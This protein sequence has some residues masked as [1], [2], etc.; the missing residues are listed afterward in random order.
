[1]LLEFGMFIRPFMMF[2]KVKESERF[3]GVGLILRINYCTNDFNLLSIYPNLSLLCE[4]LDLH[5]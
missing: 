3:A 1:M 2:S 4:E 5:F